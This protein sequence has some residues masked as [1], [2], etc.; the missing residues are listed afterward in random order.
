MKEMLQELEDCARDNENA[1]RRVRE[2]QEK[3]D[4][5]EAIQKKANAILDI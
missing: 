2:S 3:L 5:L 1:E 4:W